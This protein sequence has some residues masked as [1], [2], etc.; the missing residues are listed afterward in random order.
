[1]KP[2]SIPGR[3]ARAAAL[4]VRAELERRHWPVSRLDGVIGSHKYVHARLNAMVIA[5]N[6][7]DTETIEHLFGWPQLEITRRAQA[8]LP[9]PDMPH[10]ERR[11]RPRV[12]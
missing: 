10:Q 6:L 3:L 9:P 11:H 12:T 1:M 7:N 2:A 4:E 5:L 8:A